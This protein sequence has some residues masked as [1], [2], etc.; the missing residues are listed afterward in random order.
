VSPRPARQR[1]TGQCGNPAYSRAFPVR[2]N[3]EACRGHAGPSKPSFGC[4]PEI[5]EYD[6]ARRSWPSC[7]RDVR[8]HLHRSGRTL[9]LCG[10]REQPAGLL[11]GSE[12]VDQ[13]GLE[14]ILP[15]IEVALARARDVTAA[16]NG[17]GRLK[18]PQTSRK[19]QPRIS[20][21]LSYAKRSS[22]T[23]RPSDRPSEQTNTGLLRNRPASRLSWR[24][25]VRN[26]TIVYRTH[27]M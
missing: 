18:T 11:S 23:L 19:C 5:A 9:L 17:M 10:V 8:E 3:R 4:Y 2:D 13:V 7:T 12:F 6:C 21:D 20:P 15:N 22:L 25:R 14:N 24:R 16:F 26:S 27:S 1:D